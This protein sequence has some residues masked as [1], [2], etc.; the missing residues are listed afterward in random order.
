MAQSIE[1]RVEDHFKTELNK[2]GVRYYTKTERVNTSIERALKNAESKSGGTGRNYPDIKVMLTSA[3]NRKIPVMMEVKGTRGRLLKL[4]KSGRIELERS[5]GKRNA[6]TDFAVNGAVHYANAVLDGRVYQE[7]IA[8]GLNGWEERGELKTECEIYYISEDNAR[9][10]KL[11]SQYKT[12]SCLSSAN[13]NKLFDELNN[14]NLTDEERENLKKT[15]RQ[16]LE[17]KI[18]DIHQSIYDDADLKTLLGTN[19]KLYLFS[20]LIMAALPVD[21]DADLTPADLKSNRNESDHDGMRILNRVRAFLAARHSQPD[22]IEMILNL[23]S[24]VFKS[25]VLWTPQNG[26]SKIKAIYRKIS[27]EV[28]PILK[29]RLNVDFTGIILNSLKD[30]MEL[31]N[32]KKND[33]VLTPRHVTDLMA[34]LCRTDMNS[35]IW[36]TAM[37]S[38]G[39]LLSAM[40]IMIE[41]VKRRISTQQERE[42][43]IKHIKENQ[44]LGI[45]V[46]GNIYILAVINMI[47]SGDGSTRIYQKNSFDYQIPDNFPFNVFLL[48][49]PYSAPGKGLNFVEWAL[50][51]MHKGYGA[52]LIQ[53][54]AGSGNGQ[55]YAADILKRNTLLAS[56]HMAD[57]FKGRS[58]V[59]TAIYLF[60]V[61]QPHNPDDLVTFIDFSEDGYLRQNRRKSSEEVN[62]QDVDHAKERYKEIEAIVLGKKKETNYYN[63]ENGT[64]IKDTITLKGDDW[65]FA[66]HKKI[67]ITPTE[68]DFKQ[69]V[70]DYLAWKVSQIIQNSDADLGKP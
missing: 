37:G 67:D 8:I 18:K 1:E 52:V 24:P 56:I 7:A 5:D 68:E 59:Q 11:L 53:E 58:G 40:E 64:V 29:L 31:E 43:K 69:T 61:N 47:L 66:Q 65:T 27:E 17:S 16:E 10:P 2:L 46:L 30:W 3:N 22:K 60:K 34:A 70:K 12:L 28:I 55:P 32:D 44:L 9:E 45:E 35:F 19:D 4:D 57:I 25:S 36:D 51:H 62:L 49:P 14:V 33:V 38:G 20:G 26:E 21:G 48:N 50:K 15:K 23:L 54:N 13:L 39:F 42:A 41:D 63:E 6:I